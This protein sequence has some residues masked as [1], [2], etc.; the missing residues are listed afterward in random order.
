[1]G[2]WTAMAV[3]LAPVQVMV[4]VPRTAPMV[5]RVLAVQMLKF[6]WQRARLRQAL[7]RA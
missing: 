7:L 1:M 5:L 4:L 2:K 6:A 3:L